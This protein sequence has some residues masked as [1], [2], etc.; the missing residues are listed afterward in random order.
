[1]NSTGVASTGGLGNLPATWSLAGTGDFDGD[2][3]ADLLWLDTSGNIAMWFMN[4]T[5][6]ASA[7][8]IGNIL[9]ASQAIFTRSEPLSEATARHFALTHHVT[10]SAG[11]S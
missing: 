3:N 2:G 9:R 10:N 5:T 1:M 6:V 11:H 7:A 8:G 4:G